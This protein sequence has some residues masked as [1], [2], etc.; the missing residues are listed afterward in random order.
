MST[1][2]MLFINQNMAISQI[3]LLHAMHPAVP[4]KNVF[5]TDSPEFLVLLTDLNIT[6]SSE[7]TYL[8]T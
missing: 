5:P 4:G 8:I 2:G 1:F 7:V 6:K 3:P